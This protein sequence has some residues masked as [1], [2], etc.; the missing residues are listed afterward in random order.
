MIDES[1]SRIENKNCSIFFEEF[2]ILNK[3]APGYNPGV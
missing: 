2:L 3:L 1:I